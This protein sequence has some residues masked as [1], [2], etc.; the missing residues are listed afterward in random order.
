MLS[1]GKHL[2]CHQNIAKSIANPSTS[3]DS[4]TTT[5]T[6]SKL[7][8]TDWADVS[9][10]GDEDTTPTVKVDSL[11]LSSLSLTSKENAASGGLS[12]FQSR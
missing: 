6:P 8:D 2:A 9:D 10:D 4:M 7:R 12:H 11:D 1:K 3:R 5:T